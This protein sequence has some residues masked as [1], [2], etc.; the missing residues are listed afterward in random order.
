MEETAITTSKNDKIE[1]LKEVA[2]KE[3]GEK[4]FE[5]YYKQIKTQSFDIA[6]KS[7]MTPGEKN[8][9]QAIETMD[10]MEEFMKN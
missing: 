3:L 2:I 1:K 9:L 8:G 6:V 5:Q 7:K 10:Y 4:K